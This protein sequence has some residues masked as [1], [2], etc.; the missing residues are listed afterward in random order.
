[1]SGSAL[2]PVHRSVGRVIHALRRERGLRQSELAALTG[3]KQPNLSRIE[4]GLVVPRQATL[5]KLSLALGITVKEVLS[6]ERA[7]QVEAQWSAA[8]TPRN[9]GQLFAGQLAAVPLYAG[10]DL[11]FD[12]HGRP[13]GKPSLIL[14]LPPLHGRPFALVSAVD[15]VVPSR[16]GAEPFRPGE[17]LVF[18]DDPAPRSGDGAF[19]V[20]AK[21]TGFRRVWFE[22]HGEQLRLVA[23]SDAHSQVTL[24][25]ADVRGLWRLVLRLQPI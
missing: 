23:L 24:P 13:A 25:R 11:R 4:N 3:L 1:M 12:A 15:D 7:R 9:A 20:S 16:R 17:V 6:P 18:S 10:T 2:P 19:V 21:V 22:S 14:Q 5:E 8:M